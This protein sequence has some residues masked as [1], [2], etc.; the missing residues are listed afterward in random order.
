M[1]ARADVYSLGALLR[2]MAALDAP[3]ALRSVV[4]KATAPERDERYPD[5]LSLAQDVTRFLDGVAVSA[6]P[7]TF[8]DRARR[9]T[10][11]HRIAIGIVAAYLA[12]RALIFLFTGR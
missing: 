6:H 10:K 2:W 11:R 4:A 12:G 5:V 8:L 1:D 9:V 7:E 3:V